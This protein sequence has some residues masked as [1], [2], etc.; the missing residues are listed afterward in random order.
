[1]CTMYFMK[2]ILAAAIGTL[3]HHAVLCGAIAREVES[4]IVQAW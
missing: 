4:H 1:M 3:E 2:I